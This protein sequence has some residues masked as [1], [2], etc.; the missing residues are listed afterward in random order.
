MKELRYKELPVDCIFQY[1]ILADDTP[2]A[3]LTKQG[4][5]S[6]TL[7]DSNFIHRAWWVSIHSAMDW[8]NMNLI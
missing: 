8:V 3:Y 5:D 2:V 4:R 1:V 7:Y 6:F